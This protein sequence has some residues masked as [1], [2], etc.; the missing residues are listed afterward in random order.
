[1]KL[2]T[3]SDSHWGHKNMHDWSLRPSDY[4]DK[5]Y[6]GLK[7]IP[8]DGILIHCGDISMGGDYSFYKMFN[9]FKFKKWLV[10]GNH[11]NHSNT[12]YLRNGWDFVGEELVIKCFGKTILFT[13][14]PQIKREG[15]N[16]NIHGH[17]HG[18]KS[19][20]RPDFYDE[21]YHI[22]VTPEVVGYLPV[23]VGRF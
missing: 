18:G 20:G 21:T 16:M 10:K 19:R 14:I 2:Y 11:D 7:Q 13:H 1:M 3:I 8:E 17:L 4:E 12:W 23:K 6:E 22:E 15:I 9:E 5:I